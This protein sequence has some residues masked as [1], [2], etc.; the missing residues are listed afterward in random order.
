MLNEIILKIQRLPNLLLGFFVILAVLGVM[1]YNDPPKTLCDI[2]MQE[3][4][5]RLGSGFFQND[6]R[7][8][9]FESGV[10]TAFNHCLESNSPGGCHDMFKRFDYLEGIVKTVPTEC[11]G[12][13]STSQIRGFLAKALRLFG[14]I[15]WGE[16]P[17][18]NK[19]N[20]TSWLDTADLGL[21]C[22]LKRQYQRLYGYQAWKNFVQGFAP[23]LPEAKDLERKKI[24][25]L[26]IYT[27]PCKGLY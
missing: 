1:Y 25:E 9:G 16:K 13:S 4:N 22:R 2:Q 8:G 14:K 3:V 6:S 24:F 18:I 17:P 19:Y 21:F 26:C 27:Y 23:T 12:H 7:G 20:K 11:G 10:M 5:K 15:A